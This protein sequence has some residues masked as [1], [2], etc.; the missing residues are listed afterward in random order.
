MRVSLLSRL[1]LPVFTKSI[2]CPRCKTAI[3]DRTGHHALICKAGPVNAT[4]RHNVIRDEIY[5]ICLEVNAAAT[6]E[7][8]LGRL[9]GGRSDTNDGVLD[10]ASE[11]RPAD[12][13]IENWLMGEAVLVDV[14]ICN[15]HSH[16]SV[17]AAAFNAKA[18]FNIA[19][20]KK[21]DKYLNRVRA[22]GRLLLLALWEVFARMRSKC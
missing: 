13:M 3:L 6:K 21:K 19:S 9:S 16:E 8:A 20:N 22:L 15:A 14:S 4:T 12:V 10:H 17:S 11:D 7:K 18:T 2:Q 1:G 5:A